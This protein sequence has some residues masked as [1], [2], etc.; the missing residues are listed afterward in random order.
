M[1]T[2]LVVILFALALHLMT[3]AFYEAGEPDTTDGLRFIPMTPI[4]GAAKRVFIGSRYCL[5]TDIASRN[6]YI[7]FDIARQRLLRHGYPPFTVELTVT[8]WDNGVSPVAIQYDAVGNALADRYREVSWLR[9]D[10]KTWRTVTIPLPEGRF[11]NGQQTVSDFRIAASLDDA[12]IARVEIRCLRAATTRIHHSRP[13]RLSRPTR[14]RCVPVDRIT[15][16]APDNLGYVERSAIERLS[17]HLVAAG[18]P[19]VRVRRSMHTDEGPPGEL[20]VVCLETPASLSAADPFALH[21]RLLQKATGRQQGYAIT[22]QPPTGCA[23]VVHL[24]AQNPEGLAYAIGHIQT[25]LWRDRGHMRLHLRQW[26]MLEIPAFAERELYIN[27]GYGLSRDPITPDTWDDTRWKRYLDRLHLARF[28]AWSFYLWGDGQLA[29]PGMTVNRGKNLQVHKALRHAIRYGHERGLRAGYHFTPTMVP[30]EIWSSHPELQAQLEYHQPGALCP[31]QPRTWDYML[32]AYE[33]EL[34]W[35]RECDLFS[36][37]FYDPGGCMCDKCRQGD[38]QLSTLL[39]QVEVFSDLV[40]RVNPAA[41]VQIGTWGIWRYE[42]MHGYSIRDAFMQQV[43]ACLNKRRG[44]VVFSDGA[45]VDPGQSPLFPLFRQHGWPIKSFLY[46][47]NIETGQP[48]VLPLSR[49]LCEWIPKS[50][51]FGASQIFMMRMECQTK[52]PADFLGGALFWDPQRPPESVMDWYASYETGDSEAG[53]PL[54]EALLRMDDASWFG[55]D[56]DA[57]EG[58]RIASLVGQSLDRLPTERQQILEWLR[59]TADGYQLLAQASAALDAEDQ[60]RLDA[61]TAA[62][63]AHLMDSPTFRQQV[64]T[65]LW[66]RLFQKWYVGYFHSGW[67]SMHY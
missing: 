5:Q 58:A 11:A 1:S 60:P 38:V 29:Y 52:Y 33:S 21:M 66:L 46:Q 34:R 49:Y 30:A 39:R 47:T 44:Q 31:S 6:P 51:E 45:L 14:W 7:Y 62:F 10:S 12:S 65:D 53:R 27:I 63:R 54:S 36:I 25:H 28:S 23:S 24:V 15:I 18:L 4:D 43:S 22:T 56:G 55:F 20:R 67:T 17:D 37:W 3:D 8:Y 48:F 26:D 32:R 40:W 61:V 59:T 13:A 16:V 42:Q 64:D 35:F 2:W 9:T 57:D 41:T 19:A 50:R